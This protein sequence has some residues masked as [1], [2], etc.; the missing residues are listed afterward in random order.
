MNPTGSGLASRAQVPGDEGEG[1][2]GGRVV[3][4][5]PILRTAAARATGEAGSRL[6]LTGPRLIGARSRHTGPVIDGELGT[7]LRSRREAVTPPRS[8]CPTAPRRRTPGLRRAELATLA[9]VSVDYLIR[10][11]QGRDTHPSPQVLAALADGAAPRARTICTTFASCAVITNGASCAPRT[12][13]PASAVRPTVQALL[14]RLEPA[15][16]FV[17]NRLDRPPGLDRRLRPAGAPARHP[18]R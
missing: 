11:E 10:I 15:P 12:V 18:R 13:A 16:A 7:F 17:V 3:V 8:A 4:M 9:G 14:D 6:A 1:G 5:A 2:G